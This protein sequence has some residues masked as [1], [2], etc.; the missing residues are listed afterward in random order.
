ML[1][2]HCSNSLSYPLA[3][4]WN[5]SL[6]TGIVPEALKLQAICP[7]HK[8]GSRAYPKNYRPISLTSCMSKV[9]EKVIK[10]KLVQYLESNSLINTTQHGFRIGRST[11]TNLL[12]HYDYILIEISMR[13][14]ITH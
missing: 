5:K 14:N 11:L 8:G 7:I 4:F 10:Q 9:I 13:I 1:L 12:E 6:S 2:K 3:M